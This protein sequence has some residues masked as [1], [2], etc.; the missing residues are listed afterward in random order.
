MEK[1]QRNKLINGLELVKSLLTQAQNQLDDDNI[2]QAG[3]EL[4]MANKSLH[5]AIAESGGDIISGKVYLF[6][7]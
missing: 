1:Q 7:D 4:T 6:E 3:R 5:S 2:G